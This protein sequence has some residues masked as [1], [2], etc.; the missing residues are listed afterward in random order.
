MENLTIR[1]HLVRERPT[2][3]MAPHL[4]AVEVVRQKDRKS[5]SQLKGNAMIYCIYSFNTANQGE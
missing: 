4:S 1:V 5:P 3:E 2:P